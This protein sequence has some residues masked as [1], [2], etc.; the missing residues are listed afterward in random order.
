MEWQIT[1]NFKKGINLGLFGQG[2]IN[3]F[4]SQ[5]IKKMPIMADSILKSNTVLYSKSP[6]AYLAYGDML[7]LNGKRDLALVNFEKSI[8]LAEEQ[9]A[10]YLEGLKIRYEKAK[11]N[12]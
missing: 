5:K 2:D 4:G 10:P 9:K 1:E 7:E 3:F 6:M 8:T 12:K 11:N